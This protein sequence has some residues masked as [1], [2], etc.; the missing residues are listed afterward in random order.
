MKQELSGPKFQEGAAGR[1]SWQRSQLWA[2]GGS[3]AATHSC[4]IFQHLLQ[5]RAELEETNPSQSRIQTGNA[6]F[7]SGMT[8]RD[9][10]GTLCLAGLCHAPGTLFPDFSQPFPWFWDVQSL[11]GAVA[12]PA[13]PGAEPRPSPR[14]SRWIPSWAV[15]GNE[16]G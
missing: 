16:R 3:E 11:S 12:F 4:L 8:L 9:S 5:P 14:C 7:T 2:G 15:P 6:L 10:K 1:G 13:A